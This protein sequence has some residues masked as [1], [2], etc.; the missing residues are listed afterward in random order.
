[1]RIRVKEGE[2]EQLDVAVDDEETHR[3]S[4]DSDNGADRGIMIETRTSPNRRV[5]SSDE[6]SSS[7]PAID[8]SAQLGGFNRLTK[9]L[10]LGV[11]YSAN[12]GGTATL[13]GTG[14]N[15]VLSGD[16]IR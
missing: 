16:I 10:M 12:I 1:M 9:G 13:T 4:N 8:H 7:S 3:E 5:R 2:N 14:L 6:G 11:A 15:L